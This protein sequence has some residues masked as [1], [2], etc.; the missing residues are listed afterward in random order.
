MKLFSGARRPEPSKGWDLPWQHRFASALSSQAPPSPHSPSPAAP[1][2]AAGDDS[3]GGEE[4]AAPEAP[5]DYTTEQVE[6]TLAAS[7]VDGEELSNVTPAADAVGEDMSQEGISM[8]EGI[9]EE[10]EIDPAE[11]QDPLLGQ[12]TGGMLEDVM[13]D[14]VMGATAD[15]VSIT[16]YPMDS[17]EAADDHVNGLRDA[18]KDCGDVTMTLMGEEMG[19]KTTTEEI[20]VEGAGAAISQ[21]AE[22]EA[23]GQ[24]STTSTAMMSVGNVVI[25]IS[26]PSAGMGGEESA[27]PTDYTSMLEEIAPT[28]VEGPAEPSEAPRMRH[29]RRPPTRSPDRDGF[30]ARRPHPRDACGCGRRR[31]DGAQ[32]GCR[33][34]GGAEAA[35]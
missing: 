24:T 22:V 33:R 28:F 8:M 26:D 13:E 18:Y 9:L 10:A 11:C 34:P 2:A 3:S 1:A 35:G 19:I 27:E 16:A 4:S 20:D 12:L 25:S 15:G 29:L 21:D 14:S 7:T 5:T 6:S 23:Q 31:A 32:L 30:A 17:K